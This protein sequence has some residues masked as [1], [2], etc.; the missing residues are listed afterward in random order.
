MDFLTKE[1]VRILDYYTP[2][3]L[4]Y[5]REMSNFRIYD[6]TSYAIYSDS[7]SLHNLQAQITA[8]VPFSHKKKSSSIIGTEPTNKDE[9]QKKA[10][11]VGIEWSH[12][13]RYLLVSYDREFKIILW[14]VV[15]CIRICEVGGFEFLYASMYPYNPFV[16]AIS[17]I[18]PC[19]MNLKTG[20][21]LNFFA[22]NIHLNTNEESKM[23]DNIKTH[24]GDEKME[25]ININIDIDIEQPNDLQSQ[26]SQNS[27]EE[28]EWLVCFLN[29][30]NTHYY[31]LVSNE[32]D[33]YLI[34]EKAAQSTQN[35]PLIHNIQEVLGSG[36][37]EI[38]TQYFEPLAYMKMNFNGQVT[39]MTA[40]DAQT[41]LIFN[42]TDRYLR[43][44]QINYSST[45]SSP[46]FPSLRIKRE[47]SDVINKKKWTSLIYFRVN[48]EEYIASGIG[49]SG[50]HEIY[51]IDPKKGS[52]VKRLE[53]CKE[54]CVQLTGHYKR[55]NSIVILTTSGD[56]LLWSVRNPKG[57]SALAP[58]FKEVE[59]NVEYIERESEFDCD[60][61]ET[62]EEELPNNPRSVTQNSVY[63]TQNPGAITPIEEI[64]LEFDEME[65]QENEEARNYKCYTRFPVFTQNTE[66][67]YHW[68]ENLYFIAAS[69]KRDYITTR[70][71]ADLLKLQEI[72]KSQGGM[73]MGH[74]DGGRVVDLR[75]TKR[76]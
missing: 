41:E 27:K 66:P 6:N 73:T 46:N 37:E 47:V 3:P 21:R 74:E 67:M 7:S 61:G 39:S 30:L 24:E 48:N 1:I 38:N 60:M 54:G 13:S 55:H 43:V 29:K 15:E 22:Q 19:L 49:E 2:T 52:I 18:T 26:S 35:I 25:D 69:L 58:H 28:K 32:N 76:G 59:E 34:R 63:Q 10:L 72:I 53:P 5:N 8:P 75:I 36:K 65:N 56:L 16:T 9:K 4:S 23:E 50:S 44:V 17:A 68:A 40:D 51:F 11:I 31:I 12:D 14:D 42:C 33:V 20:E 70:G 71:F 45:P 64:D 62:E 57:W